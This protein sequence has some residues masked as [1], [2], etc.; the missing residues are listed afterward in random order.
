[1]QLRISL[2]LYECKR[3]RSLLGHTVVPLCFCIKNGIL[4]WSKKWR[5]KG[6]WIC[7]YWNWQKMPIFIHDLRS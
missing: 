5:G 1:M 2:F 7:V 3:V 6:D 4:R